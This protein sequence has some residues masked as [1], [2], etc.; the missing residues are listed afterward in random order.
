[1]AP[2]LW[3]L[4]L[5]S[6][7]LE[8]SVTAAW[9]IPVDHFAPD[10]KTNDKFRKLEQPPGDSDFLQPGDELWDLSKGLAYRIKVPLPENEDPFAEGKTIKLD[11]PWYG[12]WLVWNAR[13]GMVVARGSW[14]DI[15]AAQKLIGFEDVPVS[16]RTRVELVTAGKDTVSVSLT[17]EDTQEVSAKKSGLEVDVRGT[18]LGPPGLVDG[19]FFISWPAGEKDSRW[20]VNAGVTLKE[21]IRTRLA[22]RG[23]GPTRCELFASASREFSNGVMVSAAR[24]IEGPDGVISWPV[25]P[26]GE[27]KKDRAGD[28]SLVWSCRPPF[29][30]LPVRDLPVA[31]WPWME[32]PEA[33]KEW[34]R[35]RVV[36]L[37]GF[38]PHSGTANLMAVFDPGSG[39]V[40]IAGTAED[41][42]LGEM[43]ILSTLRDPVYGRDLWIEANPES[44]GWGLTCRSG[45]KA[46]IAKAS[47]AGNGPSFEI[48]P[49]IGDSGTIVD[50]R[51]EFDVFSKG[52]PAGNLKSS[53]TLELEKPQ[54]IASHSVD[55]KEEKVVLTVSEN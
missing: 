49:M 44:G 43:V 36:D 14:N 40:V 15:H 21:G 25:A 35:G 22:R 38:L 45:E 7:C 39:R 32:A 5:L 19:Q 20:E 55:G 3:A 42:D 48:E 30:A 47:A 4:L 2:S 26:D 12:E 34:V 17:G 16:I 23:R 24:L 28:G 9:K 41:V 31:Q 37:R 6:A 46:R 27:P 13:S 18:N 51:Y 50:L 10:Y 52:A 53:T 11:Q 29:G 1:M 54:Q 8:A 33:R